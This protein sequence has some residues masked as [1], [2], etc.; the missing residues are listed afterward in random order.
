MTYLPYEG[1]RIVL[2]HASDDE[3]GEGEG[4]EHRPRQQPPEPG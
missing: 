2:E 1:E 4:D 3:E